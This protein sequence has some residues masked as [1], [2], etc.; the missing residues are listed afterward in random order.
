MRNIV[1]ASSALLCAAM[2]LVGCSANVPPAVQP[3]GVK[4]LSIVASPQSTDTVNYPRLTRHGNTSAMLLDD[5]LNDGQTKAGT[6]TA[7]RIERF[8]DALEDVI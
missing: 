4:V 6:F 7:R 5:F 1:A 2:P 8:E 3:S